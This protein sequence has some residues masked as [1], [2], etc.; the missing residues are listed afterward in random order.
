MTRNAEFKTLGL[1]PDATWEDIKR[2][3]R[4]MA[5]A[6]HPDV[7][8]PSGAR[9]FTEITEAYMALKELASPGVGKVSAGRVS[10]AGAE[11]E[12]GSGEG[13]FKRF[14]RFW[15]GI[16][17]RK[18]GAK[19]DQAVD[20]MSPA[21]IRF[22]G[23]IISRAESEMYGILSKRGECAS[24]VRA[25]AIIRRMTSSRPA[26]A[27]LALR[28]LSSRNLTGDIASAAIEHFRKHAPCAEVMEAL[29]D[30]FADSPMRDDILRAIAPHAQKFSEREA[31]ALL[32]R[33]RRWKARSEFMRP[34]LSHKS[35]VVVA[36]A[37]SGWPEDSASGERSEFA[38]L[39]G[40][41]D[42]EI[43]VPLLR[44]L[45]KGKLPQWTGMRLARLMKEH[46]S[47]A[48]RVWASSIVRDQNLS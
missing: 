47:P 5:R 27:L 1:S 9:K 33:M 14:K 36:G 18:R 45:R 11:H 43:L 12:H 8:G 10:G 22:I 30:V 20:A 42:E 17:S 41:D 6:Y 25:D 37:L 15:R 26:V 7:A 48:V 39:L 23:G 35:P 16:F 34:F 44:L 28:R 21:R 19:E 13:A 4:R 2:A 40:R 29:L 38:V 32:Y 31:V 46:P 24:R 3:F